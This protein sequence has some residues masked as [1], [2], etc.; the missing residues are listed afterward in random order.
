MVTNKLHRPIEAHE[1]VDEPLSSPMSDWCGVLRLERGRV[2]FSTNLKTDP[3]HQTTT[4]V[5][6]R[7]SLGFLSLC[8]PGNGVFLL[9]NMT[10]TTLPTQKACVICKVSKDGVEFTKHGGNRDGLSSSCRSCT[11][12]AVRKRRNDRNASKEPKAVSIAKPPETL[13]RVNVATVE[14]TFSP[15]K[16]TEHRGQR[17]TSYSFAGPDG[18]IFSFDSFKE[19]R[20]EREKLWPGYL[21]AAIFDR[22]VRQKSRGGLARD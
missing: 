13:P 20:R 15:I 1:V 8:Y 18:D 11:K 5:S 16:E 2:G 19:A 14:V 9:K 22:V 21:Q 7:R 6:S 10:C 17:R 3:R 4:I 12:E